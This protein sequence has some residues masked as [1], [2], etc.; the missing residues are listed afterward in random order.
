[1]VPVG[2]SVFFSGEAVTDD[3]RRDFSSRDYEQ[4]QVQ[5]DQVLV[6]TLPEAT[7]R[8]SIDDELDTVRE[9]VP[10][11]A[12]VDIY[13]TAPPDGTVFPL[14]TVE[15]TDPDD[16]ESPLPDGVAYG[17]Q[18]FL[19][20]NDPAQLAE[21]DMEDGVVDALEDD[22]LVL[23]APLPE[24]AQVTVEG[25]EGPLDDAEIVVS[26]APAPRGSEIALVSLAT[27]ER[28]GIETAYEGTLFD[29]DAPLSEPQRR[30]LRE[31]FWGCGGSE[32][33]C[34][35]QQ[36]RD[37]LL[38]RSSLEP[39]QGRISL[40]ESGGPHARNI[41]L[42]V[43]G[44][45]LAFTLLIV[46]VALALTSAESREE[47]ALL[48]AMGA[49]PKVRRSITTWQAG[50]LPAMAV[51]LAVPGGLAVLFAAGDRSDPTGIG[52]QV[53]WLALAMLGIG[54][55]LVSAA[56]AWLGASLTGRHRH[57]LSAIALA[58]D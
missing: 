20:A 56:V 57:D 34:Q 4:Y 12:E 52:M 40:N 39:S 23:F 32:S 6:E 27:A 7:M 43:V 35:D 24:G 16:P 1:M 9:I 10:G 46:A 48:D 30:A 51:V 55:P 2:L 58:S 13:M 25:V 5:T 21:T 8:E 14:P 37:N 22:K 29:A 54:V 28:W 17:Q 45:S 11:A 31:V 36:I 18:L 47:R 50:L 42:A 49:P 19:V 3:A 44:G 33:T 26:D 41:Q 15:I 53:P 38:E